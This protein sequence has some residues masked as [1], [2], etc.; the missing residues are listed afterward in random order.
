MTQKIS[1]YPVQATEISDKD[2]FDISKL[3]SESPDVYETQS[4]KGETLKAINTGSA[5]KYRIHVDAYL[6]D[7]TLIP[8]RGS[9]GLPF[10]TIDAAKTYA[11]SL[12]NGTF[13]GDIPNT[14]TTITNISDADNVLLEIG[15]Y[16]GYTQLGTLADIDII[17]QYVRIISKNNEGGNAN[18]VVVSEPIGNSGAVG[19]AIINKYNQVCIFVAAGNYEVTTTALNGIAFDGATYVFDAG[20]NVTKNTSG[21][22]FYFDYIS[23]NLDWRLGFNILGFA[24]FLSN[25]GAGSFFYRFDQVSGNFVNRL[26]FNT[27][28]CNSGGCISIEGS[29]SY[30][31]VTQNLVNLNSAFNFNNSPAISTTG[32]IKIEAGTVINFTGSSNTVEIKDGV[33]R[34]DV[35]KLY[36]LGTGYALYVNGA[37]RTD[38]MANVTYAGSVSGTSLYAIAGSDNNI[39]ININT[40]NSILFG[41]SASYIII[42]GRC[43]K[44]TAEAGAKVSALEMIT[45]KVYAYDGSFVQATVFP[46]STSKHLIT[47]TNTKAILNFIYVENAAFQDIEVYD[48]AK[49]VVNGKLHMLRT[50]NLQQMNI[51][52][53]GVL[54]LNDDVILSENTTYIFPVSLGIVIL[55]EGELHINKGAS[56]KNLQDHPS[57]CCVTVSGSATKLT[58]I[59]SRAGSMITANTN[60]RAMQVVTVDS[61]F[62]F[63]AINGYAENKATLGEILNA[64][65]FSTTLTITG[66]VGVTSSISINSS[67]YSSSQSAEADRANEIYT[68]INLA[69][70]GYTASGLSGSSFTLSA[71]ASGVPLALASLNNIN[72]ELIQ[73]NSLAIVESASGNIQFDVDIE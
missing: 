47:G 71:D 37:S 29:V 64:T 40:V 33:A 38:I 23:D 66:G 53:G 31:N 70:A 44:I 55:K 18:S 11:E 15:Q 32:A 34:F 30:D 5:F 10:K 54:I 1:T 72:Q 67:V 65:T 22:L 52:T 2:L 9:S 43:L 20:T 26:E 46:A 59:I 41:S 35:G 42:R 68:A 19:G 48:N 25:V 50:S 17:G 27:V 69:A 51:D 49:C 21:S 39:V 60:V 28:Q 57:A 3:I 13:T 14:G 63:K 73:S 61:V 36:N 62:T 45:T 4:I 56:I 7:D 12:V 6:G 8:N 24:N 58:K 16:I